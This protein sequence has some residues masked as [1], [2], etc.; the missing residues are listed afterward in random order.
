MNTPLVSVI[1]PVYNVEKTLDRCLESICGQ[2]YQNLEIIVVNDGSPDGSL[3]ICEQFRAKD[4][5]VVVISKENEGLSLTRNAGMRA[6]HGKYLQFVDSDDYIEP[7]FTARMVEA[8]EKNYADLVIA[9]YWMVIPANSCKA[10]Q[11]LES[12]QENL[13]IEEKRP[14]D[15]REYGFLPEGIYD[16][17][18]FALR[19]MEKPASFFYSVLWNKLYRRDILVD[20]HLQFTS[21]VRW[22][23]D[24]VFNLEYILYANVFVS[25]PK[26][27][28]HY[29]QNPQSICHTQINLASIVQN[30]L[31]VF[32][33]Y[34]E[35]YTKLGLYDQVQPQLYK[36]LT[37]FSEN[38]Y[39]SGSPQ[40]IIMDMANRWGFGVLDASDKE[41][42]R[43]A[44]SEA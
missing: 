26:A 13:G 42:K 4:P 18:T 44:K 16:R 12:L 25:I 37:A 8:A 14:D 30:K 33:Y 27:G 32:R 17:D 7:T 40:K 10:G 9:P 36:F 28:Y 11:A 1:V 35:L 38:A 22:A 21:E 15:V 19:L 39:P 29:V 20:N 43:N 2:S 34:K 3:A 6:A 41:K 31:Q 24:L 23:E 5:R